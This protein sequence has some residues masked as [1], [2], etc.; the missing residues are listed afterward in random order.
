[1]VKNH[2]AE[3]DMHL[4]FCCAL[5]PET[6]QYALIVEI[7]LVEAERVKINAADREARDLGDHALEVL[8]PEYR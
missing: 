4:I 1:M 8:S 7:S 3:I 6:T 2:E 5:M